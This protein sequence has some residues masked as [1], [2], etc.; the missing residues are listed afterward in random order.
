MVR[1]RFGLLTEALGLDR[2]RAAGWTLA[3]LL[4]NTLRDIEDGRT[5]VD[6]SQTEV[7]EALP[8]R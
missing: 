1:R 7:A 8:R 5:A 6:P 2:R 4:Q 3:R